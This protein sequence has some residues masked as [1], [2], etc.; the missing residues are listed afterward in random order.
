MGRVM[1]VEYLFDEITS[2]TRSIEIAKTLL[3]NT[4]Q[5]TYTKILCRPN[6][7]FVNDHHI[8]LRERKNDAS[9]TEIEKFTF[10]QAIIDNYEKYGIDYEINIVPKTK[11]NIDVLF[12]YNGLLFIGEGKGPSETASGNEALLRAVLEIDTYSKLIDSQKLFSDFLTNLQW[13]DNKLNDKQ[14]IYKAILIFPRSKN[15]PS[16][17]YR[18]LIIEEKYEPIRALMKKLHIYAINAEEFCYNNK[19]VFYDDFSLED[20]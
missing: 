7:Y 16:K 1:S 11:R 9:L 17:M 10:R 13:L 20:Y 4:D 3:L 5:L 2:K 8:K 19:V 18:Q 14:N 6:G 15:K 12:I